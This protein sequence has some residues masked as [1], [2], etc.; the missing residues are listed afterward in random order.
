MSDIKESINS[1]NLTTKKTRRIASAYTETDDVKI[2]C[3]NEFCN[4]IKISKNKL[5]VI[6][7]NNYIKI[8]IQ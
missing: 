1:T 4:W 5:K 6:V 8:F 2:E 7:I 3:G